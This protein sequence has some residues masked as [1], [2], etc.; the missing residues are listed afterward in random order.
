MIFESPTNH[1]VVAAWLG[2]AGDLTH[3][4]SHATSLAQRRLPATIQRLL[5]QDFSDLFLRIS[6]RDVKGG[7]GQKLRGEARAAA[8]P[9]RRRRGRRE[10]EGRGSRKERVS[11]RG[12]AGGARKERGEAGGWV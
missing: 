2:R 1:Q 12:G 5:P 3:G 11:E 7:K 9:R 10:L 8:A 6:E 4:A